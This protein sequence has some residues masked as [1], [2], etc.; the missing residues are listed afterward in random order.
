MVNDETSTMDG[1]GPLG[2]SLKLDSIGSPE[3]ALLLAASRG[4]PSREAVRPLWRAVLIG[5]S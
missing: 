2:V 5:L 4:D 3:V 1:S